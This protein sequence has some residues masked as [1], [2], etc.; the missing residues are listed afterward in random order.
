MSWTVDKV[1]S[2]SVVTVPSTTGYK[3]LV[4]LMSQH[5]IS[6]LPV[7]DV[8]DSEGQLVGIV[9][10]TDLLAKERA[11]VRRREVSRSRVEAAKAGAE[12]AGGLMTSPAVTVLPAFALI[13]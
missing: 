5:G 13:A 7:V 1:M 8:V 2:R 6:A 3:N 12:A 9:S 11:D 10:E 4:A